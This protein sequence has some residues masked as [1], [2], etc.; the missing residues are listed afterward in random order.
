MKNLTKTKISILPCI[1]YQLIGQQIWHAWHQLFFIG[2]PK[3]QQV[4]ILQ[5]FGTAEEIRSTIM[6]CL[7][8]IVR[9]FASRAMF[10]NAFCTVTNF[11]LNL[12]VQIIGSVDN[13]FSVFEAT[14]KLRS[15]KK[16]DTVTNSFLSQSK[17]YGT[18]LSW[19]HAESLLITNPKHES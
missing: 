2:G 15:G 13:F 4:A 6:I 3:N 16:Y 5:S 7:S 11:H 18:I 12:L 14:Q 9:F 1:Y 19:A 17:N 8:L 10:R